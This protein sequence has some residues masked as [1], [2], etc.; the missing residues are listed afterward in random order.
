MLRL[1]LSAALT[2]TCLAQAALTAQG[3]SGSPQ[4]LTPPGLPV[5]QVP[6]MNPMT[7][8][9]AVLGKILFWDEQMSSDNTMACGTCH[10]PGS[11]GSDPRSAVHPGYDGV[12]GSSD[13]VFGSPS[14]IRQSS[15]GDYLPDGTF[16][17]GRQ[18]T[19][20]RPPS[21]V[22]SAFFPDGLFWD[23]RATGHF[24]DPVSGVTSIPV[25]GALESQSVGPP[26]DTA[27]MAHDNRDWN[28]IT[29][30]LASADPLSLASELPSDIVAALQGANGNYPALFH[31]AFGDPTITAERIAYSLATYQ[32]TLVPD[33]TPMDAIR[34]GQASNTLLTVQQEQGMQ[35]F[36]GQGSCS[37]CHGGQRLTSREF[38]NIGLRPWQ[39]DPGRMAVTGAFEDRGKFKTPSLRNVGLRSRLMHNGQFTTITEVIAFYA[40]GGDFTD[41]Q[42]DAIPNIV[43]NSSEEQALVAFVSVAFEDPRVGAETGVFARPTLQSEANPTPGSTYGTPWSGSGNGVPEWI[44][45][46]PPQIGNGAFKV[47]VKTGLGGAFAFLGISHSMAPPGTSISGIP[48]NV[49][50]LDPALV[51]VGLTLSGSGASQGYATFRAPIPHDPALVGLTVYGQWWVQ[52]PIAPSGFATSQGLELTVF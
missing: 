22:M 44:A 27:E 8:E 28:D 42:Y 48:M 12:T 4:S 38:A 2:C 33:Q 6:P 35:L 11:G 40:R 31:A 29:T 5:V 52:D 41:G 9:K 23:G 43:L 45:V 47:G 34:S 24:V 21:A 46:S 3:T 36:F 26:L 1:A 10:R 51:L 16:G 14:I 18:V 13:D 17:L 37:L 7:A 15:S 20:R 25:G 30:K 19:F 39:E 49:N 32:R 50:H